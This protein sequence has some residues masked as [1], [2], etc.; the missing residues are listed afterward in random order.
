M[1]NR[2]TIHEIADVLIV[3]GGIAGLSAAIKIKETNSQLEV[4]V[5]EKATAGTSGKANKGAGIIMFVPTKIDDA[6]GWGEAENDLDD[7]V[8]WI[9]TRLGGYLNDQKLMKKFALTTREYMTDLQRWGVIMQK[10]EDAE[11]G[12]LSFSVIEEG[13]WRLVMMDHS[14]TEN[15]RTFAEKIGVRFIDKTQVTEFTTCHGTVNGVIGFNLITGAYFI[16]HAKAVINASGSCDYMNAHM[17][18]SARGDG[19]AAAYR[20]GAEIRDGEFSN[21]QNII[22]TGN[23]FNICG[24]GCMFTIYDKNM[25]PWYDK[26]CNQSDPDISIGFLAGMLREVK[27]GNGPM[28]FKRD[29]LAAFPLTDELP[30]TK[31]FF[32]NTEQGKEKEYDLYKNDPTPPAE[33]FFLGEFSALRVDEDMKT[34]LEGLWALGDS[35]Y[36]GSAMCGALPGPP[37]RMRG[38]GIG[39]AVGSAFMCCKSVCDYV[40]ET[41]LKPQDEAQIEAFR[42]K[43]YEPLNREGGINPRDGIWKLRCA[44]TRADYSIA[45]TDKSIREALEKIAVVE[46]FAQNL[47]GAEGDYH[48]LGLC[49]DLKNMA[50]CA[51]LYYKAALERRESRGFHYREDY[52]ARN[53]Y[54]WGKW[55]IQ[56]L[57]DGKDTIYYEE[58]PFDEY[59]T[60]PM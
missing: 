35:S 51:R 42:K 33:P 13:Y 31:Q 2:N 57:V 16:G 19:I 9:T 11:F 23:S 41:N 53:D 36:T 29:K 39:F 7:Y 50:V 14:S 49:Q 37:G 60:C 26:Y 22:A 56:K 59:D 43:L 45:K 48:L 54:S 46:E 27:N 25:N 24:P 4:L 17:W 21:F 32:L 8:D 55:T 44:M 3:G 34:T 6:D 30:K 40:A 12:V 5:V 15:L 58:V 1:D 47:S 18:L 52:P 28:K 20:A 38:S 10:D